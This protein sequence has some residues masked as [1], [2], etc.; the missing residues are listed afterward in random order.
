[1]KNTSMEFEMGIESALKTLSPKIDTS[2]LSTELHQLKCMI[3]DWDTLFED[4]RTTVGKGKARR[5]DFQQCCFRLLPG[6]AVAL[7]LM[8]SVG[9][10]KVV[11]LRDVPPRDQTL[12]GQ[13]VCERYKAGSPNL[14]VK[15]SIN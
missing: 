12:R 9:E 1:M 5:E 6:V 13:A 7:S 4:K 8:V 15:Q 10:K 11:I 3:I 2:D 14:S